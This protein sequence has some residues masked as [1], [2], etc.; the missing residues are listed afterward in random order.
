MTKAE[1]QAAWTRYMHRADLS[2]DLEQVWDHAG[3]MIENRLM[4]TKVD[5]AEIATSSPQL[6]LHAGLTYL[7]ELVMDDEGLA[8]EESRFAS[9][10]ADYA[11]RWS[12]KNSDAQSILYGGRLAP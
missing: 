2:A 11:M 1:I 6:Y 3:Q 9:A 4:Q 7:H 12:L 8:R 5:L 10:L